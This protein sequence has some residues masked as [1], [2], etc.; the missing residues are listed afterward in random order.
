[1]GQFKILIGFAL[2]LANLVELLTMHYTLQMHN[3]IA[4][5]G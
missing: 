3:V 4:T 1:M 2:Y 5:G